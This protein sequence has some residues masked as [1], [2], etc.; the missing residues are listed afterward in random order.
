MKADSG[1]LDE[2]LR[3]PRRAV[4]AVSAPMMGGMLLQ[5]VFT[6]VETAF[7][8]RLGR[9]ALAAM[10]IVFPLLFAMIAIVNGVGTGISALVAQAVGRRDMPEAER[11]AGTAIGLGVIS[12]LACGAAGVM[13]GPWLLGH[14][15]ATQ[16]VADLAW[17]YFVVLALS[18]PLVFVGAF[19]RFVLN[20]EG[21]STTPMVVLFGV[22]LLNTGLDYLFIFPLAQGIRGAALA[23]ALSQMVATLTMLYLLLFRRRNLVKL[24]LA[25]LIPSWAT[26]RSVLR[27][28][29]PNSL[30]QL[31]VA[32]GVMLLN[33]A[34][35]SFGDDALAAFG[36]G[37]RVDQVANMPV[38]GLAAGSVAVIGM[39]AGAGRA[40]LVRRMSLY[41]CTWAFLIALTL[42]A[43]AF[44]G[45]V[46]L[47]RVFTSDAGTIAFGRHYLMYMVF[48]Y[49]LMALVM[50][51]S[52]IL[53]GLNYPNLS[54]LIIAV[55]LFVLAL[56]IAYVSIFLF[57]AAIDGV[58]MGMLIG[59][60]GGAVA[61]TLLLRRIVWQGD[62]TTRAAA[63]PAPPVPPAAAAA[64]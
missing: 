57:H 37:A 38:M 8:G 15:G 42:G 39:F 23:G 26:V 50:T 22:T 59:T 60:A 9:Q 18:T 3:R 17:S 20:G 14:F 29:V 35:G 56:P 13:A 4:W 21:D 11:V 34:V 12:G 27:V 10:T 25:N 58:W 63:S 52:R 33:R 32:L 30:S 43:C 53:L 47:M 24:H 41:T 49:P 19:L 40:D 16:E 64:A 7:V 5:V 36:V 31:L 6:I 51:G 48:V 2:F 28:G 62:P 54:L 45:S 46:P 1:R 61:S 55:R 44:A